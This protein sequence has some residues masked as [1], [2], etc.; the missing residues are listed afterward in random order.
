MNV[1]VT[2]GAGYIGSHTAKALRRAGMQPVVFD[3]LATGHRS[4]VKWGPLV[5]GDVADRGAVTHALKE[6]SIGAVIHF[7]GSAY[8]GESVTNPR[9]YFS[10]NVAGSLGLLDAALDGGV[11]AVIFSSTCA[12]Y[13]IPDSVPITEQHPQRPINP[14]GDSKV[15]V[16]RA[17]HWY[18]HAYGLKSLA[19]RYFNVAGADAD[20]DVGEIHEPETHLIPSAIAAALGRRPPLEVFGSDYPTPDRTAVRD[21]VHVS[22]L[23]DAHVRALELVLAGGAPEALNL[24]AERGYSVR[25]VIAMVELACGKPVP[26]REAPRRA[27]DPAVLVADTVRARSAFGWS[28]GRSN[29]EEM[30]RSAAAWHAGH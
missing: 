22:D 4:F 9:K 3:N 10:N 8:V 7:A 20:G 12:G 6:H 5:V 15:F 14:Y 17:L 26:L 21:Y 30:V 29:L 19:L 25:E 1:L 28:P 2:G 13:G 24:G 11:S 16:E 23:A 18:G 27:G